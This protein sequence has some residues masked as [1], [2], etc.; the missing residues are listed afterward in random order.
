MHRVANIGTEFFFGWTNF[1]EVQHVE[2]AI[3][4]HHFEKFSG[5]HWPWCE[6]N[7]HCTNGFDTI[8]M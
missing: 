6:R 7:T 5:L 4:E 8:R 3:G 1:L 2:E